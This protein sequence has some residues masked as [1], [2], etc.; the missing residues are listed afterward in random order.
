[1]LGVPRNFVEGYFTE[2]RWCPDIDVPV[3]NT[4]ENKWPYMLASPIEIARPS[5]ERKSIVFSRDIQSGFHCNTTD[6]EM[7]LECLLQNAI[8]PVSQGNSFKRWNGV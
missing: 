4:R 8:E 1:M 2:V 7:L 5:G 3:F 6:P